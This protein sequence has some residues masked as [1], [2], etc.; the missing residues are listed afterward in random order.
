MKHIRDRIEQYFA[1]SAR[2]FYRHRFKTLIILAVFAGL[3]ISQLP[4]I[5][6]D[7]STEG[8]LHEADPALKAYNDFRD[9]FGNTEMIIIAVRS[10]EIFAPEF[11]KKL[12]KLHIELRDTVPYVDDITSL[13]NARNTRGEGDQLIVEDLLEH[14]PE[15]SEEL[16]AVKERALANPLYKNQLVSEQGD[17]TAIVLQMQAYSSKGEEAE[18][19]LAGFEDESDTTVQEDREYLTDAENGEV[20]QAVTRIVDTYRAPDFEIYAAGSPVVTDF[21]KKAMMKDMR[22]FL[23]LAV[24]TIAVFL[25]L[26]FRR[27][28]AV[29]LP[30]LVVFLS[31]LSTLG[32]M[33]ACGTPIKLP[34]QIL[35]SFLIA[36]CVG[37]SVHILA[38]FF[39]R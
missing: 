23:G 32:L 35:P 16:A 30:L 34:T 4:K 3:L 24:L 8:F 31:L 21:L 22:K 28:S 20:V 27:I 1:A 33:A 10:K 12:K 29:F 25:F 13:I 26:M 19:V 5:T 14:W 39:H 11:L 9:Q 15:T 18:D 38:I 37:D 17:F 7:T 36:V 2:L 6:V